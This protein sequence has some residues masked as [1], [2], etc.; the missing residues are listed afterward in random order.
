MALFS[1]TIRWNLF[2]PWFSCFLLRFEW[3]RKI[4]IKKKIGRSEFCC[5]VFCCC[6]NQLWNKLWKGSFIENVQPTW[7]DPKQWKQEILSYSMII[8]FK[9]T[10]PPAAHAATRANFLF[11]LIKRLAAVVTSRTPV[12]PNGWPILNDPKVRKFIFISLKVITN[13][14]RC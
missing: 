7:R 1:I 8:V 4:Y 6:C 10:W 14:P 12:A 3:K 5:L 11:S 2:T 13:L 9:R